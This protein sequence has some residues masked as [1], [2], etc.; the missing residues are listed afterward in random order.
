MGGRYR[1]ATLVLASAAVL[2]CTDSTV[3]AGPAQHLTLLSGNGQTGAATRVL[4]TP[5][6]LRVSDDAGRP[7]PGVAVTWQ[8]A[9]PGAQFFPATDRTDADGVARTRW[10][11]GVQS[12]PQAAEATVD[13][14]DDRVAATT[15]A[16]AGFKAIALMRGT[17]SGFMCAIDPDAEA[18]C[19]STYYGGE[20]A[21]VAPPGRFRFR[22]L[23]ATQ[24]LTCGI[25]VEAQLWCWD[26]FDGR[27]A[28]PT[29][30]QRGVGLEFRSIDA[31]YRMMCGVT[32]A[33]DGY[34]WGP[35]A[36]GD[37]QP[38]RESDE[39]VLVAGSHSWQEISVT[40]MGACGV[41]I[42]GQILCWTD[43]AER[44]M[45]YMALEGEGPFLTPTPVAVV[46]GLSALTG[47]DL[48]Q[49]G[50]MA[51]GTSALCWGVLGA[52]NGSL[53]I[54]YNPVPSAS[55]HKLSAAFE[56][57]A[58]LD[59]RGTVWAWGHLFECCHRFFDGP[60]RL[61]PE[62]IWADI[63]STGSE[64]FAIAASDSTVHRWTRRNFG[65]D[66]KDVDDYDTYVSQRWPLPV[67]VPGAP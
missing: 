7:V 63:E 51:G 57:S 46:S 45:A 25:T 9:D 29:L 15:V 30:V 36:F 8:S 6:T 19:W 21:R 34:C 38:R 26:L 3:P 10:I 4:P 27:G 61:A 28:A 23:A 49:C 39:P 18:W 67:S 53:P 62:G 22:A 16:T 41:T 64:L 58:A 50:L 43:L 37:G 40:E 65:G 47:G 32:P 14:R 31:E 55:L 35:G 11:L 5:L 1:A 66:S 42:A 56:Q 12:G 2:A 44:A 48:E 13:A 20:S 17:P 33:H 54:P 59:S 52:G 24:F 60:T